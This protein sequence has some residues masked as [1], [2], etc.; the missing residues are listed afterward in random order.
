MGPKR[1]THDDGANQ[2]Q[3]EEPAKRQRQHRRTALSIQQP[4]A[5]AS[6]PEQIHSILDVFTRLRDRQVEECRSWVTSWMDG[7]Y[8]PIPP[9]P[10]STNQYIAR[11][12]IP[13]LSDPFRWREYYGSH[14]SPK[15]QA[16]SFYD[17]WRMFESVGDKT[18][19]KLI[20]QKLDATGL[21]HSVAC[22]F[23]QWL[24]KNDVLRRWTD[25]LPGHKDRAIQHRP[26]DAFEVRHPPL[27]WPPS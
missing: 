15:N 23:H 24:V 3:V 4:A 17:R 12:E 27:F 25:V 26:S 1:K 13:H 19:S 8:T 2:Q 18:M 7:A 16:S 5:S 22:C 11:P 6:I 14:T 9:G 20:L 21:P 10:H